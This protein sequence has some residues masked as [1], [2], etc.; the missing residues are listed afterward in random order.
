[1][2]LL[3]GLL[4]AQAQTGPVA[5]KPSSPGAYTVTER[6]PDWKVMQ[7]TE[8]V[9]GTNRVHRYTVL[10]NGLNRQ[11]ASGN[12][13]E[14]NPS[15]Q[16]F[17]AGVV[18][19][20]ASY[21]VI[22]NQN[23]NHQG[24]V[25]FETSD[26]QR[27][28][29]HPLAIGFFDPESGQRVWLAQLNDCRAQVFSNK[30]V[31]ANAF[32]NGGLQATVVYTYGSGQFHQDILFT[33]M[34]DVTPADLG[35][36]KLARLEIA[37]EI[38][39][40]PGITKTNRVLKREHNVAKRSRMAEP[41]LVDE[42][43]IF[44]GQARMPMGFA[45]ASDPARTNRPPRVPVAKRLR[46]M[47]DGRTVLIET[48]EWRDVLGELARLPKLTASVAVPKG[49]TLIAQDLPPRP[50]GKM[51]NDP[52][53]ARLSAVCRSGNVEFAKLDVPDLGGVVVD[54]VLLS[55][56]GNMT[57][58]AGTYL[59]SGDV[60]FDW[61]DCE[62]GV[63]VEFDY[64]SHL[65]VGSI[66]PSGDYAP[67]PDGTPA[68]FTSA[69]GIDRMGG[70]TIDY[71]SYSIF[72]CGATLSCLE[73]AIEWT[74]VYGGGQL[75][76]CEFL[77]C[78]VAV[79]AWE[80][81]YPLTVYQCSF[82]NCGNYYGLA[83][84]TQSGAGEIAVSDSQFSNCAYNIY[85]GTSPDSASTNLFSMDVPAFT[86]LTGDKLYADVYG[87]Y[88]G[89]GA[90]LFI[91]WNGVF[92]P[93]YYPPS[94]FYTITGENP[95]Q[96]KISAVT[97]G[98]EGQ[99]VTTF[100]MRYTDGSVAWAGVQG[101][102]PDGD[103]DGLPD[104]WE[105]Q[106][107]GNL[108]QTANGDP[109]GDGMSNLTEFNAGTDPASFNNLRLGYWSFDPQSPT[110]LKGDSGQ[111]PLAYAGVA[112]VSG[113]SA[114][115]VAM[116][117]A[118]T[119]FLRY[120]IGETTGNTNI[121]PSRG[122]VTF[123]YK[124]D[125]NSGSGP[126]VEGRLLEM[127]IKNTPLGWWGLLVNSTGDNIYFATHGS[128][129]ASLK[130]HLSAAIDW[131][132]NTWHQ[133][134]FV[135][136]PSGT[137]LY[138]D[139]KVAAT[140]GLGVD[141]VYS[142]P[143]FYNYGFRLGSDYNG[144]NRAKGTFDELKVFNYA[145]DA[146]TAGATMDADGDQLPDGWEY[147]WFGNF[148]HTGTAL[149]ADVNTLLSDYQNNRDPN[150]IVFTTSA[151]NIYVNNA[152]TEL[153]VNVTA[154]VPSYY[155][156]LVDS[157]SFESASWSAFSS[158]DIPVPLGSTEGWHDVWV[159]LKGCATEAGTTWYRQRLNLDTTP[160]QITVNNLP[161][162]TVLPM[163]QVKGTV[164]E[165]LSKLTYDVSNTKSTITG[166][167]GYTTPLD[168]DANQ[169][170]FTTHAFQCYDVELAEEDNQITLHATDLAGNTTTT[171][172][173]VTSDY[174][175]D[176]IAPVLNLVWPQDGARISG[177][178]FTL[179]ATLDDPTASVLAKI[180]HS[181]TTSFTYGRVMRD[182]AV[183]VDDLS[184]EEGINVV[185]LI[186]SDAKGNTATHEFTVE[187][188]PT[189]EIASVVVANVYV[190]P[191]TDEASLNGTVS[192]PSY[193]V[194]VNGL[195]ATVQT[196][197]NEFETYDWSISGVPVSATEPGT[198]MVAAG[199]GGLDTVLVTA[200]A[201]PGVR[202]TAAHLKD[203]NN[204]DLSH[205]GWDRQDYDIKEGDWKKEAGGSEHYMKGFT[206]F[207]MDFPEYNVTLVDED[208]ND[209]CNLDLLN[210]W[211]YAEY[212]F[213]IQEGEVPWVEEYKHQRARVAIDTG[214]SRQA[215]RSMSYVVEARAM[216]D[217]P[218]PP[219]SLTI[220]GRKLCS[221]GNISSDTGWV[222]CIWGKTLVTGVEGGDLDVTPTAPES[223]TAYKFDVRAYPVGLTSLEAHDRFVHGTIRSTGDDVVELKIKCQP[224]GENIQP[225][226][227][228][229]YSDIFGHNPEGSP[230]HLTYNSES[231]I[232][233]DTEVEA[234]ENGD[235][236][237]NYA[238]QQVIFVKDANNPNLL[239]FYALT[240][241]YGKLSVEVNGLDC[242][243]PFK[244]ITTLNLKPSNFGNL[245]NFLDARIDSPDLDSIP[246]MAAP[247][248]PNSPP[249][250]PP[251]IKQRG[252]LVRTLI[253]IF[254]GSINP[255]ISLV[256]GTVEGFMGGAK[257]DFEGVVGVWHLLNSSA[258]RAAAF[259]AL[260]T[261]STYTQIP[262][263]IANGASQ[264]MSQAEKDGVTF[265]FGQSDFTDSL[266]VRAFVGGYAAGFTTEQLCVAAVG[267]GIVAK[268]SKIAEVVSKVTLGEHITTVA[269]DAVKTAQ[270]FK[271]KTVDFA[272]N[273]AA[274]AART[275]DLCKAAASMADAAGKIPLPS[276]KTV[277]ELLGE[278]LERVDVFMHELVG[279]GRNLDDFGVYASETTANLIGHDGAVELGL[280]AN[281]NALRENIR[282]MHLSGSDYDDFIN[283]FRLPDGSLDRNAL[284]NALE[285]SYNAP[286]GSK[287]VWRVKIESGRAFDEV[288]SAFYEHNQIYV[289]KK[290]ANGK[291][292]YWILDSYDT[293]KTPPEIISRKYTQLSQVS[294]Q[295][296]KGYL[297]E[298]VEKYSPNTE[299][300]PVKSTPTEL[301]GEKLE[302][303]MILEVPEQSGDIPASV[304]DYATQKK[305][306]IRDVNGHA[307]NTLP[308]E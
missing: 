147:H 30:V 79:N 159:G 171:T 158:S 263:A 236:P 210:V 2:I 95:E 272:L 61:L 128:S 168:Y 288:Q 113:I 166:E 266:A 219:E 257:S 220:G 163:I 33:K 51:E 240:D 91:G 22:L 20:G 196:V 259:K 232:L 134:M 32:T 135:W 144:G 105:H 21:S 253:G 103:E 85:S 172:L 117:S 282:V 216:S 45:F 162:Q 217:Y 265:Q 255:N 112:N 146:S 60:Y 63:V 68:V 17:P 24:S 108:N 293:T 84:I 98:L 121:F 248:V 206:E 153:H 295:T 52:F 43:L 126:G 28:V 4:A 306:L 14:C 167:T 47:A 190:S 78:G 131:T 227:L 188:I 142:N 164:N 304:L 54:Y 6:G 101:L 200:A 226:D 276:G 287:P 251:V 7:K 10:G 308:P 65:Y 118:S 186:A 141:A 130:T 185:T 205:V 222:G 137:T 305:I 41:D 254:K 184:L 235:Y 169:Q 94:Y 73:T 223:Y 245:I 181:G 269:V 187:K 72:A 161:S 19:T 139:G 178:A 261:W 237:P 176:T 247:P 203:V 183:W 143:T 152:N 92:P 107:F 89:V 120:R 100:N 58:T 193:P 221:T 74:G 13:V 93:T 50:P 70:I 34:P 42:T 106:Y 140:G 56:G 133:I 271:T 303:Q 180:S 291:P 157:E 268:G 270:A 290:S 16:R 239:H 174:S 145:M 8:M 264:F 66:L 302:G 296:G 275:K 229:T 201:Q 209:I 44:S 256:K 76:Q 119:T 301:V 195:L 129:P 298:F 238:S 228:G 234:M 246:E 289:F 123:W 110:Y 87:D 277:G 77:N 218:L 230:S 80:H 194:T 125:W 102:V 109:D 40:A 231:E 46:S 127:G 211:A 81:D 114:N 208:G 278:S 252:L 83:P 204:D 243:T 285:E 49:D 207:G 154:G 300:A 5:V 57:L 273:A 241:N 244:S 55:G 136:S 182:G 212:D 31:Y 115:A 173:S 122:T 250:A 150:R 104:A 132:A 18:C 116:T 88:S 69:N 198:F 224:S 111:L 286:P 279:T 67:W 155:S 149:D 82:E 165:Q 175:N 284:L 156:V 36:G 297:D 274:K 191:F 29:S 124:P 64:Y 199:E 38:M 294:E 260:T 197:A 39:Q 189:T 53:L 215:G 12:W 151:E 179:R 307:Y 26:G 59:V 75:S 3:A 15:V 23:L 281:K 35:M 262:T 299:I 214:K 99:T 160:P 258:Q 225:Q 267:A 148:T 27:I 233:S 62:S 283:Q 192:D 25:D 11:D 1:M 280:E 86:P 170:T 177:D 90:N 37:T 138:L 242:S 292:K 48:V 213:S 71:L 202:L 96:W 249:P 97:L 9:N